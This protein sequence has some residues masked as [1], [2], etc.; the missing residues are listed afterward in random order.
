MNKLWKNND[1]EDSKM[2][3]LVNKLMVGSDLEYD[4]KLLPYDIKV[5]KAYAEGLL[6]IHISGPAYTTVN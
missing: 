5:T 4:I 1:Q 3:K 2:E 6:K